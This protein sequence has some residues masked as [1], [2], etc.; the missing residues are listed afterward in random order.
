MMPQRL[1]HM[2]TLLMLTL[3]VPVQQIGV[4]A[5]TRGVASRAKIRHATKNAIRLPSEG[6]LNSHAL[7][8]SEGTHHPS[9]HIVSI[10][11]SNIAG[12]VNDGEDADDISIDFGPEACLVAVTGESGS[13]KSLLVSKAIDLVTGGKAVSSLVPTSAG[14]GSEEDDS[15]SVELTVNLYEPQLSSVSA[16]LRRFNIDPS[17]LLHDDQQPNIGLLHLKR[18]LKSNNSSGRLKSVCR[19]NGKHCSLKT[20]REIA[21][22]LFTRV[23]VGVAS[24]AL[25]R[26]A[27][28]LTMLDMG[29]P[30]SLLQNCSRLRDDYK[31]ARKRTEKIKYDLESRVLPSSLQRNGNG[32]LDEEQMELLEHWV[33]ELDSFETRINMFQERVLA[34]CNELLSGEFNSKTGAGSSGIVQTLQK[35]HKTTWGGMH[36]TQSNSDEDSLFTHLI[37]FREEM[38]A[39]ET[40]IVSAQSAYESLASLSAP[41]S[42]LVALENTRNL[43]YSISSEDGGPLYETIERTHELLNDAENS[44]NDAARSIDGN[45]DSL[46][47]TL[48]TMVF[49][50]VSMEE[51]DNI[52]ADW[53]ALARKHGISA[54]SLPNCHI[55]LRQEMDGNVEA[56]KLLPEA[57]EV[58]RNALADYAYACKEVS[59]ARQQVAIELSQS[60]T[61]ILPSLGLEGS[62]LQVQMRLRPGGYEEP[63]FGSETIG[64]DIADFLLLHKKGVNGD[65][66]KAAMPSDNARNTA[67]G[68][69]IEQVGSSGEKSRVLLAIETALPGSIGSTCNN[70]ENTSGQGDLKIQP[71]SIIYDEID[72]HV[73]GRA[74]VTM[75]KL[76]ADQSRSRRDG[77][78]MSQSGSQIIAITHSASLAAIAERHIVVERGVNSGS[79][80]LPIRT[81]IVDGPSRRKEIARMASGD[82]ASG[83]AETFAD[84]L[85]RDALIHRETSPS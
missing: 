48:E 79:S 44:L 74:A 28:R 82:L 75:A 27:S 31:E 33:D 41:N 71:I 11:S 70:S 50:G 78:R 47:S 25:G 7:P 57:E 54:Y 16:N 83:E 56:L 39:V 62:I 37:D 34:Q 73:G 59:D 84:A 51:V 19:I 64:V 40:Q 35:L 2:T 61:E 36:I 81:Y 13:G 21:S 58:E 43:L 9:S 66:D 8:D 45:S 15:S 6:G 49:T 65:S 38:R 30:D 14:E 42:A 69:K 52:I 1:L 10:S 77:E 12:M 68:G 18:T 32:G 55:S 24:S 3:A 76:L 22:P 4:S 23:D 67:H 60:V 72:A 46:M 5:F 17:I 20:L 26:P 85:I 80:S 63:Y 53:N 29:V